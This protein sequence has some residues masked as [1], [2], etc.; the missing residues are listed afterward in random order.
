MEKEILKEIHELKL[1]LSKLIGSD[2]E[3]P[4]N[5]LSEEALNKAQNLYLKM[6]IERGDWLPGI[7]R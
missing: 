6:S 3:S 1:I 5:Q 2:K 4:E 7:S